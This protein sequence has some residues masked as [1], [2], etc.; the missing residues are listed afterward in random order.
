MR[1]F[2]V[3]QVSFLVCLFYVRYSVNVLFVV[4]LSAEIATVD[5][6]SVIALCS[7]QLVS[8]D[9]LCTRV[10]LCLSSSLLVLTLFAEVF[11]LQRTGE[12]LLVHTLFHLEVCN[13]ALF[14]LMSLRDM[15]LPSQLRCRTLGHGAFAYSKHCETNYVLFLIY[16]V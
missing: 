13:A 6:N 8:N 4:S 14:C 16:L 3:F 1:D 15:L 10:M 12:H 11:L 2:F 7:C 5:E 9:F